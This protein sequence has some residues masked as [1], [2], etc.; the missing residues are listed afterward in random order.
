MC[1][2]TRIARNICAKCMPFRQCRG[3][4]LKGFGASGGGVQSSCTIPQVSVAA[5]PSSVDIVFHSSRASAQ[6][7]QYQE[8]ELMQALNM[9]WI[10]EPMVTETTISMG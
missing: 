1:P 7:N 6:A 8:Q 2:T 10:T 4:I 9:P 5:L 3:S